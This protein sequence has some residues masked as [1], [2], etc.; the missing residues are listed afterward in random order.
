[1]KK[2]HLAKQ[3]L[4][5]G[6]NSNVLITLLKNPKIYSID[7]ALEI[8]LKIDNNNG[9]KC[10]SVLFRRDDFLP[11]KIMDFIS[12][13]N[14]ASYILEIDNLVRNKVQ[15]YLYECPL[16]EAIRFAEITNAFVWK[17]VL[18]RKDIPLVKALNYAIKTDVSIVLVAVF[19][20]DDVQKL[21]P[22]EVIKLLKG[23]NDRQVSDIVLGRKD[24]KEYLNK[25]S[26]DQAIELARRYF[27]WRLVLAR[28]DIPL[29][30]ALNYAKIKDH[31][32]TW[33]TVLARKDLGPDEAIRRAKSVNRHSV[34]ASVLRRGDISPQAAIAL[35]KQ[36]NNDINSDFV[37]S[38][39]IT[40]KD[41]KKVLES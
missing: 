24:V 5:F 11:L 30:K 31:D 17:I 1:M 2:I 29:L 23:V 7:E 10:L 9:F 37:W 36:I 18:K 32:E 15:K 21:T 33:S 19:T 14:Q 3:M 25:I 28:K 41:V 13:F 20:R 16:D 38:A 4:D 34:W 26:P 39:V 35:A 22:L 40:R 8:V 6:A 27:L 12:R